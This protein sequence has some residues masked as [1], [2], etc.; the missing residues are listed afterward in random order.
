M[1]GRKN[2]RVLSVARFDAATPAQRVTQRATALLRVGLPQ[3]GLTELCLGLRRVVRCPWDYGPGWRRNLARDLIQGGL[4]GSRLQKRHRSG[5]CAQLGGHAVPAVAA[6]SV[7]LRASPGAQQG[8]RTGLS[9]MAAPHALAQHE[10]PGR[11][12]V[13]IPSGRGN[14]VFL[15]G[16]GTR[17]A[18]TPGVRPLRVNPVTGGLLIEHG[19]SAG[20]I[21]AFAWEHGLFDAWAF[22]PTQVAP[23]A[24]PASAA[25]RAIPVGFPAPLSLAAALAGCAVFRVAAGNRSRVRG[26]VVP[27]CVER[28]PPGGA[29][30]AGNGGVAA[31]RQASAQ[32][33]D[34]RRGH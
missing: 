15:E 1:N 34:P 6:G 22:S 18:A 30:S 19:A 2:R 11:L 29:A 32:R 13:R 25:P 8:G 7:P 31:P 12:R 23:P 28:M 21:A 33:R 10:L 4:D 17:P 9:A 26:V 14:A 20:A 24:P 3:G 5:Q 16:V 27:V